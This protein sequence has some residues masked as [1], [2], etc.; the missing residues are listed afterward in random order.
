MIKVHPGFWIHVVNGGRVNLDMVVTRVPCVGEI[1][2]PGYDGTRLRVVRV[3]HYECPKNTG[4]TDDGDMPAGSAYAAEIR[5]R[6][7]KRR[8][9][10]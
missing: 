8:R 7:I 2:A 1:L 3:E 4:I 9:R 5:V 10:G 6:N